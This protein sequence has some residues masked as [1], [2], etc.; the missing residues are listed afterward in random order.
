MKNKRHIV[1]FSGG[2]SSALVALEVVAKYGREN[3]ILLNHNISK[4][5]EDD[6]IKRFKNEISTFLKIPITYAN[7]DGWENTDQ[8]DISR[9]EKAFKTKNTPALCT[10]RLKTSPF[11]KWLNENGIPENDIIYYGFDK[12][13]PDRIFRRRKILKEM[14][15]ESDFPLALWKNR[16][17]EST[18]DIGIIPPLQYNSFKHANCIGCIK[19]GKQHWYVVY[20]LRP[21]IFKKAKETEEYIGHSILKEKKGPL[22]LK[23]LECTFDKMKRLGVKPTEHIKHQKFWADVAKILKEPTLENYDEFIKPCMCTT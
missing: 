2:H 6:D 18:E 13:E 11:H 21:D 8:F 23:D 4:R 16:R 17:Y 12:N 19:G 7:M 15:Y 3:V 14:G 5:V 9:N 1:A 10:N 22:Y 20:C